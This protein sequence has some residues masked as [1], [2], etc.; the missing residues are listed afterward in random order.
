ML[1]VFLSLIIIWLNISVPINNSRLSSSFPIKNKPIT[2]PPILSMP[3][4]RP[5]KINN[6]I[7]FFY[8]FY[9]YLKKHLSFQF[10]QISHI[11]YPFLYSIFLSF[12]HLTTKLK[13]CQQ[14]SNNLF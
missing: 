5:S 12:L 6:H 2:S 4:Q 11:F 3:T 9:Y 13:S 10:F 1:G 14:S 7:Y 8:L